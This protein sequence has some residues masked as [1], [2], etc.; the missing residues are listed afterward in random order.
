M[1]VFEAGGEDSIAELCRREDGAELDE[2]KRLVPDFSIFGYTRRI[3]Q[4]FKLE[5]DF[6]RV[7]EGL[8]LAGAPGE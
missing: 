1:K 3:K 2:V 4:A 8:R 5:E 6:E 7:V